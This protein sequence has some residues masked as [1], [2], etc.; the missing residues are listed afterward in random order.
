MSSALLIFCCLTT[1]LAAA[2][3]AERARA[4]PLRAVIDG[5][6]TDTLLGPLAGVTVSI[7]G[8]AARAVTNEKGRFRIS[9]LTPGSYIVLAQRIGFEPVSAKLQVSAAETL[10]VAFALERLSTCWMHNQIS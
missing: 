3:S 2:Q 5:E 4:L 7:A 1:R 8:S 9:D 6:V 10:R